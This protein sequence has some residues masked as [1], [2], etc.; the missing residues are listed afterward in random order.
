MAKSLQRILQAHQAGR[1]EEAEAGYRQLV[2]ENPRQADAWHLWGVLAAQRKQHDLAIERIQRALKLKPG[3]PAFLTNLGNVHLERGAAA[4]AI[5]CFRDALDRQPQE[6]AV[7]RT[8]AR[9]CERQLDAGIAHQQA[10][11]L[12]EAEVCYRDV[13][14]G[15][16]DRADAWHLLGTIALERDDYAQ[17]EDRIRRAIELRPGAAIFHNSLGA[18]L[19]KQRRLTEAIASYREALRLDPAVASAHSNLGQALAQAGE[20]EEAEAVLQEVLDREPGSQKGGRA[21]ADLLLQRGKLAEA[22]ALCRRLL[23]STAGDAEMHMLLGRVLYR[24]KRLSEASEAFQKAA[25]LQP[26]L[27][28]L[29]GWLALTRAKLAL[30]EGEEEL[31]GQILQGLLEGRLTSTPFAL[32]AFCDDPERQRRCA[33]LRASLLASPSPAPVVP[34]APERPSGR[35]RIAYVSPDFRTH[36]VAQLM[37]D[38]LERH[39]RSRFEVH[40]VAL[41][42]K[43]DD[44]W[45]QRI[46]RSCEQFHDVR[47]LADGAVAERLRGLGIDIAVDLAGYTSSSR[48]GIFAARAAPVQVNWLGYPGTMGAGFMDYI[49]A[50]AT[51][52][53]E[54]SAGA[55]SEQVVTL[56]DLYQPPAIRTLAATIPTRREL[57]LPERGFVFCCFNNTWKIRPELFAAWMR[58][59][60]HV[61]GSVLWLLADRGEVET[62]LRREAEK[63]GVEPERLVFAPHAELPVHLA[64][65]RAADLFL[66]TFPYNA[67]TTASDAL[68]AGLPLLTLAGRSFPSRV[69]A[70][71]LKAAGLVDLI[72]TSRDDYE[73]LALRLA[74]RPDELAA[75]RARLA[76]NQGM[77]SLFDVDRFRCGIE[78][79]YEAMAGRHCGA[80]RP[81]SFEVSASG[82][83]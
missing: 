61:P 70:S 75:V 17:A 5:R 12:A 13:L 25:G 55:Y 56:S 14:K 81:A 49:L 15:Q 68:W 37:A 29:L 71:L 32:L 16:P 53:P 26:D 76:A 33:E 38:L 23:E 4:E 41:A 30:W 2:R 7:A 19:Q 39:D 59:L 82:V 6:A 60:R 51:V 10:G 18:L 46:E 73:A 3:E 54:G 83:S 43:A 22:E 20:L 69:A 36:P 31:H 57:G 21:L 44:P 77:A 79:A 11:R 66:D 65:Q 28:T 47:E 35:L 42:G 8:L 48:L 72:T 58:L 45:R 40:G 64:R 27:P 52:I 67:H 74:Q 1:H 63:R 34:Q 24:R 80:D 62:N 50:D 78:A 9:M